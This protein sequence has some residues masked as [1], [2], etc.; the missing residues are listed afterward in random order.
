MNS[1]F[2]ETSF[3]EEDWSRL[4]IYFTKDIKEPN[5]MVVDCGAPRTLIGERYLFE[6]LKNYN[7]E[8]NDL[9]R[10]PSKQ[11]FKFGPSQVYLSVKKAEIPIVLKCK[12][13]ISK[14]SVITY[15]PIVLSNAFSEFGLAQLFLHHW[16]HYIFQQLPE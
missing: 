2:I 10:F 5:E 6:Y 13:V 4:S 7:M 3:E 1:N 16:K 14:Q 15:C 9:N 8:V 11:K 12:D